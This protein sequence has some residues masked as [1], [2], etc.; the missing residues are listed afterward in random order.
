MVEALT[1]MPAKT[2]DIHNHHMN[3]TLW[4]EFPFREG[5]VVIGTYG[6]AG[7]TWTQQIV[8]QLVFNGD[9]TINVHEI[10]PWWD[11]RIVP[12]EAR[13]SV[14]AQIHRRIIKTHLP[15]DALVMSHHA[16]YIYIAR[17]G[18]DVVWSMYNHHS[19]FRDE[20]YDIF[21]GPGLI[22]DPLPRP[23][24][25]VRSYFRA[26]L[27][28]DGY[29]FWSFW[30]NIASWWALREHPNVKLIHFDDLKADLEGEMRGIAAFLGLELAKDR[31]PAAIEHCTFEY[32]KANAKRYAP[33]GGEISHGGAETSINKGTNGRWRDILSAADSLAYEQKAA[34]TLGPECASWLM[35]GTRAKH[36][37]AVIDGRQGSSA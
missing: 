5:D 19:S 7:T 35:S 30:E 37:C 15:A 11:M 14:L 33:M 26:W 18:R 24:P 8:A 1:N 10:S 4:D 36:G 32:M 3:S 2:R 13:A 25:D 29:P 23:D 17:D 27:E 16:K 31:W 12:P 20:V 21:N 28:R 9:P 6:K 34:A 22:G